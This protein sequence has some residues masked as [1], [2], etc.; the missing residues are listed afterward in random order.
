MTVALILIVVVV[1]AAGVAVFRARAAMSDAVALA[2]MVAAEA[3]QAPPSTVLTPPVAPEPPVAPVGRTTAIDALDALGVD[4]VTREFLAALRDCPTPNA[5][6]ERE[7]ADRLAG[8]VRKATGALVRVAK[9]SGPDV[10]FRETVAA[11]LKRP[12]RGEFTA[13]EV[14]RAIG[15]IVRYADRWRGSL[16]LAQAALAQATA[17]DR[18]DLVAGERRILAALAAFPGGLTADQAGTLAGI[19]PHQGTFRNYRA[20]LVRHGYVTLRDGQMVATRAGLATVRD[21][22]PF[23]TDTA[24][25]V[26]A[27]SAKLVAGERRI[28]EAA[29]AAYPA[30]LDRAAIQALGLDPGGGTFR[31]YRAHLRRCGLVELRDG[32]V[33]ASATLF[34]GGPAHDSVARNV[35]F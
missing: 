2:E 25:L 21:V 14:D 3:V 23:P 5:G 16:V 27:W 28:L 35:A 20:S 24:S 18:G 13:S 26:A 17:P 15:Q 10:I 6:D 1:L 22:A 32:Q 19:S 9:T 12:F 11:E 30:S 31:N 7:M 34:P 33:V 4:P 8:H 29:V